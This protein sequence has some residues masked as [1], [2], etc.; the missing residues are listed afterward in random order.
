MS[1]HWS[2][3]QPVLLNKTRRNSSVLVWTLVGTTTFAGLWAFTAP[4]PETV[5]VQGKLQPSS[6]I[7][8]IEAP[9]GGVVEEVVVREGEAI[10]RGQTL[11]RFDARKAKAALQA[12]TAKRSGLANQLAINRALV[13]DMPTTE[14]STNQR[15][16]LAN[17]R[18]DDS[19]SN[20]ANSDALAGSKASVEGLQ[21]EL[22]A[23]ETIADR[24]EALLKAG[25][26][27]E[28]RVLE[29][30]TKVDSIRSNLEA[31]QR[32]QDRLQSIRDAEAARR[33]AQR[34][35]EIEDSLRLIADLDREISQS[36][37][38]LS[39]INI[40]APIDGLVFDLSVQR[41]SVIQPSSE[42]KPLL[43]LIPQDDLQAKVYIPNTAIGFIK[44]GQRADISLS[45]FNAG[46]YG[47][48]PAKVKRVGSDA[49]T[50]EEQKR[51][52]GTNVEGLYFPATLELEQQTLDI[53]QRKISLQP[54]MSLTA[55]LHLR[56]RRFISTLTDLLEDKRRSLE[57]MR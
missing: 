30:R 52:L 1:T 41:G 24:Y 44:P 47:Y 54:G 20:S 35:R 38:I 19:E 51:A 50:P 7:Q 13:G 39:D 2:F 48:L 15:L 3:N 36:K 14:L 22:I 40:S 53:G 29:A 10:R 34:R 5:A 17:S 31:A 8:D 26:A 43:K 12:A 32:N 18:T 25:A 4:L 49:L 57:R 11:I 27:S 37:V 21:L 55:D 56:T 46:D 28:L 6:A 33:E 42:A 45:A 16:L 23:A 9:L